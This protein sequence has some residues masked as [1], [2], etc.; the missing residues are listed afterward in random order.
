MN[1]LPKKLTPAAAAR[2]LI[3]WAKRRDVADQPINL[4]EVIAALIKSQDLSGD[5]CALPEMAEEIC[6]LISNALEES[7]NSDAV[8]IAARWGARAGGDPARLRDA[9]QGHPECAEIVRKEA[10]LGRI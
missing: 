9:L 2:E 8:L 10:L 6:L 7:D 5:V 3:N 4:L 1:R